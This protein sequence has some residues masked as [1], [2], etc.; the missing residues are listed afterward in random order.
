MPRLEGAEGVD[1]AEDAGAEFGVTPEGGASEH[2][3][4]DEVGEPGEGGGG[5]RG[6]VFGVV[7]GDVGGGTVDGV[8]ADKEGVFDAVVSAELED[9]L[10]AA[11][12]DSVAL[13]GSCGE[14][15]DGRHVDDGVGGVVAEDVFGGAF[16]DVGEEHVDF[17][18]G[19]GPGVFVEAEDVVAGFEEFECDHA[20]ERASDACD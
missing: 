17:F 2:V 5:E 14:V 20:G 18:G 15:G 8:A 3:G 19:V 16:A 11:E 10:G 13:F 12:V 9:A 7:E 4:G 6:V 1:H